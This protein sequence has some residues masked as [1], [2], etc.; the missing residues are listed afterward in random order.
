M[1]ILFLTLLLSPY[2]VEWMNM[3]S[4]RNSVTAYYITSEEQTRDSRWLNDITPRFETKRVKR[5]ALLGKLPSRSFFAEVFSGDFDIFI[6]D[7]YSSLIDLT[8]IRKLLKKGKKV[9]INID[10]IDIWRPKSKSDIIKDRIKKRVY[11][12]GAHFLCGSQIAAD[13]IISGGADKDHVFTHPFTSLHESDLISFAQKREEQPALKEKLGLSGKKL[14]LAV[15]RFIP[16]KRYD[17]LIKAWRNMPEDAVLYIIGGGTEKENYQTLIEQTKAQ[18]ITLLDFMPPKQLNDYFR[19]ADLFVHTSETET[20]GLVFNEAMANGCPVIATDRCVGAVEL[21]RDG[22][23]GFLTAVG[24][25]AALNRNMNKILAD[26]GLREQ[27]TKKAL[28]RIKP[29][30]YENQAAVHT[31]IFEKT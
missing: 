10:G 9:Y 19:A 18:N 17:C 2:R 4:E 20:W 5:G 22:K 1:K 24:D 3:L 13:S 31:A 14:V 27:M 25:E 30:T 26:D 7:G 8:T 15:G 11:H 21:V 23:E 28:E 12:S 16:L 6:I 29:Y